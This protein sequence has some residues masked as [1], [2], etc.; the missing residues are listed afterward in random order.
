M[1]NDELKLL[2]SWLR[3]VKYLFTHDEK[4]EEVQEKDLISL[5]ELATL[6][7]NVYVNFK[8]EYNNLEKLDIGEN[9][10]VL[11][12][13]VD[14]KSRILYMQ[15]NEQGKKT[16]VPKRSRY[17]TFRE[18]NG[19]YDLYFQNTEIFCDDLKFDHI[20]NI[21]SNILNGYMDLFGKYYPIFKLYYDLHH[22]DSLASSRSQYLAMRMDTVNDSLING[23]NGIEFNLQNFCEMGNNFIVRLYVDLRNGVNIDYNRSKIIVNDSVKKT[24]G[25]GYT[26][27]LDHVFKNIRFNRSKLADSE[28]IEFA[29]NQKEVA[30]KTSEGKVLE[31]KYGQE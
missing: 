11:Y 6:I 22:N 5:K 24:G 10:N 15:I 9:N 17:L 19:K 13:G 28:F 8:E 14:D 25:F 30:G 3:K 7:Q 23:L 21:D 18:V 31:K 29:E 1:R 20:Y 4:F 27:I 16:I 26:E 12:Y 2:R